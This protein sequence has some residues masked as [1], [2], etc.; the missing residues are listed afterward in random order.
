M[1]T[2][3]RDKPIISSL[4]K[5]RLIKARDGTAIDRNDETKNFLAGDQST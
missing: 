2:D 5:G 1:P 4:V 3:Q